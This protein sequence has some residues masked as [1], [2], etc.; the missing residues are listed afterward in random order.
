MSTIRDELR[1]LPTTPRDLRKFGL[2]VGGVLAVLGGWFLFR[3]RPAGPWML[4]PGLLLITLGLIAPRVLRSVYLAW[5][6]LAFVL[7]LIV[8]TILLTL[9]FFLVITPVGLVARMTGAD[10]LSRKLD[11]KATSYWVTRPGPAARAPADYE[12]QF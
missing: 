12:R 1:Q 6:S 2:L 3:Q 10:F 8:S 7:G 11:S 4:A 5:M 9:F